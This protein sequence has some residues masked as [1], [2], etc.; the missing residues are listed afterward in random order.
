MKSL[1]H[2]ALSWALLLLLQPVALSAVRPGVAADVARL[3]RWA[4]GS[5]VSREAV[6]TFGEERC[7]VACA[8]DS[9]VMRRITG[10]SYV[11]NPHI[12]PSDL[13]YLKLLHVDVKGQVRLGEMICNARIAAELVEIFREL[14]RQNYP[15]ERMQLIDDYDA[16]DERSMSHNN[17]SCFCFRPVAGS[18]RLSRHALGMAVDINPLYNPYVRLLRSGK[19]FVQPA[20]ARAYVNRKAHFSYKL[21]RGDLCH[22]LFTEHGFEWGGA[23]QSLKD[24]QHF[25]K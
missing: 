25:E 21:T 2:C 7:F 18:S 11:P 6:K 5:V 3:Q 4:V 1:R 13:R 12:S 16:D 9:G 10:K 24:Y 15:I 8:I 14:Y 19:R 20:S 23:W 22:R 17:T